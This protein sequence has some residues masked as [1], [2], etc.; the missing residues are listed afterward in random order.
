MKHV[1]ADAVLAAEGGM[2]D[3]SL[4]VL[5]KQIRFVVTNHGA[6]EEIQQESFFGV[7]VP[8]QQG[9]FIF[10]VGDDFFLVVAGTFLFLE[11]WVR[12]LISSLLPDTGFLRSPQ[13]P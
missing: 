12:H 7:G 10:R 9:Q 6:T 13:I 3:F 2:A 1:G 8:V 5:S 11:P 4:T